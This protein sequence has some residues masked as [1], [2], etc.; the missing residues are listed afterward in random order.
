MNLTARYLLAEK[1]RNLAL[2]PVANFHLRNGA[3]VFRINWKVCI[4]YL[5]A[6]LII[7]GITTPAESFIHLSIIFLSLSFMSKYTMQSFGGSKT[8]TGLSI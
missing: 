7:L 6:W 2:D 5:P 8:E 1:R 4:L 3:E